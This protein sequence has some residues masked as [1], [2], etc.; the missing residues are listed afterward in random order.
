MDQNGPGCEKDQ[1]RAGDVCVCTKRDAA[2][3][4]RR[5]PRRK[6]T[7]P[8]ADPYPRLYLHTYPSTPSPPGGFRKESLG[9]TQGYRGI[10][11]HPE[12][13]GVG[14]HDTIVV[15]RCL[16]GRPGDT[17]TLAGQEEKGSSRDEVMVG[18]WALDSIPIAGSR[19]V[20]LYNSQILIPSTISIHSGQTM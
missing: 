10:S 12:Q 5:Q 18:S 2:A 8:A 14:R 16:G 7:I 3:G 20:C 17:L 1:H 9:S 13:A 15:C 11:S 6:Q 4:F 19:V